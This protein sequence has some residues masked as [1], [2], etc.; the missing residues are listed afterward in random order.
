MSK[1]VA[2]ALTDIAASLGTLLTQINAKLSLKGVSEGADTMAKVPD[3]INAIV[4]GS[5]IDTSDADATA[6]DILKPKTAYVDGSKLTGTLEITSRS[7]SDVTVSGRTV[8]VPAGNYS[9]QVQKSVASATQ[10]TPSI[11]VNTSTGVVTATAS[12]SAGYVSSGSKSATY[13]LPTQAAQTI[14]PGTGNQTIALGRY[15]TGTQTILGDGNLKA[16]NIKK[17]V[18]IFNVTGS[19]E[20]EAGSGANI[21]ISHGNSYGVSYSAQRT[22]GG[23]I[24]ITGIDSLL[25]RTL[26]GVYLCKANYSESSDRIQS[27]FVISNAGTVT[28]IMWQKFSES[29]PNT[30]LPGPYAYQ[31]S[32]YAS[33][34]LQDSYCELTLNDTSE[35]GGFDS[36]TYKVYPI[37]SY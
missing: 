6:A 14:T 18:T 16:S 1:S 36:G 23:K 34:N 2:D 7:A 21:E 37:Y 13:S 20:A 27:L 31:A 25:A 24:I 30:N 4:T 15:L 5:G 3:K 29:Y 12:Q 28:G 32:H 19:Y 10:A 26:V 22:G 11:S 8:T 17:G 33:I 35:T 9:S